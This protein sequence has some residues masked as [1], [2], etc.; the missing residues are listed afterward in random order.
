MLAPLCQPVYVSRAVRPFTMG[1]LQFLA[2]MATENNG[3]LEITGLLTY[4]GGT[5]LQIL[6]GPPDRVDRLLEYIWRDPRHRQF[7]VL[8]V[9]AIDQRRF[10]GWNIGIL[11]LH[12]RPPLDAAQIAS[13]RTL[14]TVS[15]TRAPDHGVGVLL[16]ALR[17]IVAPSAPAA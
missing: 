15:D 3:R 8:H 7:Q 14:L 17:C 9:V 10:S 5:F 2:D 1:E 4:F 11:D 6:E 16:K 13:L 12:A